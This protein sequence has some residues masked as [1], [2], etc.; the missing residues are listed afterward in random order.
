MGSGRPSVGLDGPFFGER[1]SLVLPPMRWCHFAHPPPLRLSP[2]MAFPSSL[3]RSASNRCFSNLRNL[4][5]RHDATDGVVRSER[6][7]VSLRADGEGGQKEES[8]R[9]GGHSLRPRMCFS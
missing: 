9:M 5:E 7:R 1:T 2:L 8:E 3:P 4:N 6:V